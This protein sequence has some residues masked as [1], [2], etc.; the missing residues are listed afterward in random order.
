LPAEIS[1]PELPPRFK[2]AM[3]TCGRR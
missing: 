2:T 1:W 3:P